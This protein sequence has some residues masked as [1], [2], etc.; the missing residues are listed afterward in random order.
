MNEAW[1][2]LSVPKATPVKKDPNILQ[3]F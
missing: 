2:P 1:T 3:A